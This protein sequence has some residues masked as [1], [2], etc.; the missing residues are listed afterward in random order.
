VKMEAETTCSAPNRDP[1]SERRL[2]LGG[3]GSLL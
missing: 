3:E 2:L 1:S